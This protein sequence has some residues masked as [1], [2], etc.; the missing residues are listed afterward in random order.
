[1]CFLCS[2]CVVLLIIGTIDKQL[3]CKLVW[4]LKTSYIDDFMRIEGMVHHVDILFSKDDGC[5][6]NT[7]KSLNQ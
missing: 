3:A 6:N 5:N 7:C 2:I 1:M 4:L